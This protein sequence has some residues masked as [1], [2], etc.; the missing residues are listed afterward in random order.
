M[1]ETDKLL[2]RPSQAKI[3]PATSFASA[4]SGDVYM[5]L[6]AARAPTA[7]PTTVARTF[8]PPRP[9]ANNANLPWAVQVACVS[10]RWATPL[11]FN[12]AARE[13]RAA[14]LGIRCHRAG[15]QQEEVIRGPTALNAG[16]AQTCIHRRS[17]GAYIGSMI[18]LCWMSGKAG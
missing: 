16:V 9:C 17:T 14:G 13:R 3:M 15:Y 11:A 18:Q 2:R 12:S 6:Q 4:S 7:R 5:V 1:N 10:G 8:H